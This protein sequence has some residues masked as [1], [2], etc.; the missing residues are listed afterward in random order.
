MSKIL[1]VD[2]NHQKISQ[3]RDALIA[4]YNIPDDMIDTACLLNSSG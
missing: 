3:V 4:G 2:D 1:I